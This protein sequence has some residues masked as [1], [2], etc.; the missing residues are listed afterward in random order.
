MTLTPAAPETQ[1]PA[2][3][4]PPPPSRWPWQRSLQVRIILAFGGMFL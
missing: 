3:K 4:P 2:G 1:S